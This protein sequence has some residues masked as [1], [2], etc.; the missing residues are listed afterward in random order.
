MPTKQTVKLHSCQTLDQESD[1][2]NAVILLS[3]HNPTNTN[4]TPQF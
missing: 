4:S 1:V 2:E 3:Y